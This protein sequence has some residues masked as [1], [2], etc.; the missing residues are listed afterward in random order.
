MVRAFTPSLVANKA[1]MAS[2]CAFMALSTVGE[3]LV[4]GKGLA[5]SLVA[6]EH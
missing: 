1:T 5:K 4:A 6:K 3:A 2:P